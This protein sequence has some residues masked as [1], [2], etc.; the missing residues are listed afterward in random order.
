MALNS[1]LAHPG[2]W[3]ETNSS[4]PPDL[5]IGCGTWNSHGM[6]YSP[7]WPQS[8]ASPAH[9]G[10]HL[11]TEQK[12]S[13]GLDRSQNCLH[14]SFTGPLSKDLAADTEADP[15][16]SMILRYWR[17]SHALRDQVRSTPTRAA[18][19]KYTNHD[20]LQPTT[21]SEL[22]PAQH[23]SDSRGNPIRQERGGLYLLK[24]VYKTERGIRSFKCTDTNVRLHGPPGIKQTWIPPKET[25]KVPLTPKQLEA[26]ICLMK[27]SK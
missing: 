18:G 8:T 4:V 3:W 11:V 2:S 7:P 22:A 20:P 12:P 26:M 6:D 17:Q 21:A 27:K 25:S 24:S 1:A 5:D 13:K 16:P 23:D 15:C 19:N 14:I 10:T 9:P